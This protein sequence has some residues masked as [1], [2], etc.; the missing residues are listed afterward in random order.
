MSHIQRIVEAIYSRIKFDTPKHKAL[1]G[2]HLIT[3]TC[4]PLGLIQQVQ[5]LDGKESTYY[6]WEGD[7]TLSMDL[8]RLVMRM[9]KKRNDF[10][11]KEFTKKER[12]RP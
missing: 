9:L 6:W 4:K 7:K 2:G 1:P 3:S 8:G 5:L 10:E 11:W 12:T